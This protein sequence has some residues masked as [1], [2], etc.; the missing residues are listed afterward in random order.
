[1]KDTKGTYEWQMI[2]LI[3]VNIYCGAFLEEII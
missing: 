2:F 1:M 3:R